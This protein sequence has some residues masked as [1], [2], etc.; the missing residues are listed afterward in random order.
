MPV[1][2]ETLTRGRGH[3]VNMLVLLCVY[4]TCVI[5]TQP[6][7][8]V[9][10][11]G[12]GAP[13]GPVLV[14]P[15]PGVV[16]F[17][18]T[19]GTVL[20]CLAKGDPPPQIT[21]LNLDHSPVTNIAGVREVL[22]NGSL[23]IWPFSGTDYRQDVHA[24]VYQCR[25]SNPTGVVLAPPTTLRAEGRDGDWLTAVG[26]S[27]SSGPADHPLLRQLADNHSRVYLFLTL[28]L[29]RL[30]RSNTDE[31]DYDRYDYDQHDYD[32]YKY[33]QHDYDRYDY[34]QGDYWNDIQ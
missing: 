11:G 3:V 19:S 23:V 18:N 4:V 7:G 2:E 1:R 17:T 26:D 25:A 15:P 24:A 33:D 14:E 10:V 22:N 16:T 9:S 32:R 12:T 6:G 8:A 29:Y 34:N 27:K 20:G 28:K 31:H 5:I 30:C 13:A 21:W